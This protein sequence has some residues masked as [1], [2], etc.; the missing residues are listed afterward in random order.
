MCWCVRVCVAKL[1]GADATGPH[2]RG[3]ERERETEREERRIERVGEVLK[4]FVG[5]SEGRRSAI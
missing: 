2:I 4:Y 5:R 1:S 3:G